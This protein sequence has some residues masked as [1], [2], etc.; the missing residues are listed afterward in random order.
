[1]EKCLHCLWWHN[2]T[3]EYAK[4][5]YEDTLS[6][7]VSDGYP[8]TTHPTAAVRRK[9]PLGGA[10]R[11]RPSGRPRRGRR[12]PRRPEP[13]SGN[14]PP[15]HRRSPR[16]DRAVCPHAPLLFASTGA[17]YGS[18]AA[19][20]FTE[21]DPV[22][23]VPPYAVSKLASERYG[24][25]CAAV[26]GLRTGSL[27][28]FSV[29]GPGQRKQVVYDLIRRL[30]ANPDHLEMF[31][32]GSQ[33]RDFN[34]V[35]NIASAFLVALDHAAFTG[36]MYNHESDRRRRMLAGRFLKT[37]IPGLPSRDVGGGRP[38]EY[39]RLGAQQGRTR[40]QP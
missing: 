40:R 37:P 35:A 17:V 27:R 10:Y 8:A 25:S 31:G 22:F 13:R 24:A 32:D 3:G 1:M 12:L 39:H 30:L 19:R 23:P 6:P 16:R 29:F 9:L 36:E 18:H 20:P 2:Y 26:Y 7:C 21:L 33:V 4:G 14:Q 34:P 38:A 11:Q 28:L 15:A 5:R